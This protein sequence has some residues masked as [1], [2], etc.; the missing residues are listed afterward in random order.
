VLV[1]VDDLKTN[2]ITSEACT[3]VN[4]HKIKCEACHFDSVG[5]TGTTHNSGDHKITMGFNPFNGPYAG[6]NYEGQTGASYN[7]TT[8]SPSTIVTNGTKKE[9]SNI[10]CHGISMDPNGGTD[11]TPIW[12]DATTGACGMPWGIA[13]N[14]RQREPKKHRT[15]TA[16]SSVTCVC[17]STLCTKP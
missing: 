5:T 10:Y 12:D 13:T 3:H 1:E 9:C 11:I 7:A 16:Q 14:R 4:T 17:H 6:G 2:S 15:S 8:T